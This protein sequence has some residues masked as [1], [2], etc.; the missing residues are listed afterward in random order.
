VTMTK[1]YTMNR[2]NGRSSLLERTGATNEEKQMIKRMTRNEGRREDLR[3][4][5]SGSGSGRLRLR[6]RVRVSPV[7]DGAGTK[8]WLSMYQVHGV[9]RHTGRLS[10][11]WGQ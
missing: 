4:S 7:A 10:T 8:A 11:E 6:L 1:M 2:V 5:G 3:R 9:N